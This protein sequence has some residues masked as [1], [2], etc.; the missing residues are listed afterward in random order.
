MAEGNAAVIIRVKDLHGS[1]V[2]AATVTLRNEHGEQ[3]G[4]AVAVQ[5][6]QARLQSLPPGRYNVLVRA[7]GFQEAANLVVL[8]SAETAELTMTMYT[9]PLMGE[10][11][12]VGPDARTQKHRT[13]GL[14]TP[15]QIK[16][17]PA[18]FQNSARSR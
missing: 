12:A 18:Q 14:V 11:A 13:S 3:Q 16:M 6:G 7:P 8:K 1:T 5:A 17:Q 15:N 10:T 9:G 2:S 4:S